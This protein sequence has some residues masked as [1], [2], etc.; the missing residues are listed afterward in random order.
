VSDEVECPVCKGNG[1]Y[2]A[3]YQDGYLGQVKIEKYC[4][5]CEGRG[6]LHPSLILPK[7]RKKAKR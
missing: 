2:E 1:R 5:Q 6:W 4:I 3:T 7:N